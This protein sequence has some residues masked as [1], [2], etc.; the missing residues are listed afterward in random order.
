MVHGKRCRDRDDH[1]P[2]PPSL[3]PSSSRKRG[4]RTIHK[5]F[6]RSHNSLPDFVSLKAKRNFDLS[7]QENH[8]ILPGRK[9]NIQNLSKYN[10]ESLFFD[11][12]WQYFLEI[13]ENYYFDL[14]KIFYANSTIK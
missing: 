9:I 7:S 5:E 4:K 14:I 3:N 10:L 12:E 8:S 6:S 1:S 13:H 2:N 11:L